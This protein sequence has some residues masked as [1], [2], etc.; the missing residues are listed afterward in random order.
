MKESDIEK[1]KADAVANI[2]KIPN[3]KFSD[4]KA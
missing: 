1:W 3:K 2:R 4:I